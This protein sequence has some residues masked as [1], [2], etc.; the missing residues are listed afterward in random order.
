VSGDACLGCTGRCCEDVLVGITGYDAWR[1]ATAHGLR[2]EDFVTVAS[3]GARDLGAFR[4]GDGHASL[5]LEKNPSDD[6]AFLVRLGGGQ[7]RCGAYASRPIVCRTYP[8]TL[9]RG[10]IAVRDD[11]VCSPADWDLATIS[12]PAWRSDL[13]TYAREWEIYARAIAAWNRSTLDGLAAYYAF[14]MRAFENIDALGRDANGADAP[15]L[16]PAFDRRLDAIVR[17]GA[18]PAS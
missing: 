2:L 7:K 18:P 14:V 13:K 11:V 10:R 15:D 4:F 1:L 3:A 9:D 16:D 5:V 17:M 12:E 8:M 6:R